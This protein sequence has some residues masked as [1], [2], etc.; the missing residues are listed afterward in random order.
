MYNCYLID[1][2]KVPAPELVNLKEIKNP[3]KEIVLYQISIIL[4]SNK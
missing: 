3:D 4:E 1:R 2:K